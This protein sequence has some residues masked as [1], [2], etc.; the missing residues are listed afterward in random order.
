MPQSEPLSLL[1]LPD[2]L[3]YLP[4]RNSLLTCVDLGGK[5]V[6]ISGARVAHCFQHYRLSE[7]G[8]SEFLQEGAAFLG[9][10][11]S[12]EPVLFARTNFSRQRR[13]Q[14]ELGSVG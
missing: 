1:G 7:S 4:A 9:P 5:H 11:N 2:P 12:C 14:D 8:R 10:R 6:W 3:V 13:A